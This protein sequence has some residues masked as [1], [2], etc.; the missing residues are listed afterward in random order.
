M[1]PTATGPVRPSSVVDPSTSGPWCAAASLDHAVVDRLDED[2]DLLPEPLLGALRGQLLGQ[3]G[4]VGHPVGDL[5]LV[6]L[7]LEAL[8][9]GAVL[10]GVAEDADR[11]EPRLG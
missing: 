5:V 11:V 9:L 7:V 3:R 10:V 1:S 4:H 8:R 2:L 6:E